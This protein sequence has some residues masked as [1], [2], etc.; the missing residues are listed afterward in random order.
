[1]QDGKLVGRTLAHYN[2]G[3][4]SVR[5]IVSEITKK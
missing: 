2:K 1:M 5:V 4:D 3:P